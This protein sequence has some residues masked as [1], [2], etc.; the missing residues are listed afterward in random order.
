MAKSPPVEICPHCSTKQL[1][2]SEKCWLCEKVF[3]DEFSSAVDPKGTA[4]VGLPS[5]LHD[6]VQVSFSLATLLLL[7]TLASVCLGL[8]A[9]YP[10]LGI[11]A[12]LIAMPVFF[13]TLT[14][15]R[16]REK[17]GQKVSASE[18]M[19]MF[20]TSFAIGSVLSIVVGVAAFCSFCGVCL[21]VFSGA[22]GKGD[23]FALAGGICLLG[24][25]AIVAC[26]ALVKWIRRRYDRETA[27]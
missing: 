16:H 20:I 26:I 2:P 15:V 12:C 6:P 9:I 10:G 24:V 1:G 14:V 5:P 8:F 22:E 19:V 11:F 25:V 17:R 4:N 23:L 3:A 21:A 27:D 13:R 7:M 18:K